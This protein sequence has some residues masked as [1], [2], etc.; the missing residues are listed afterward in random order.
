MKAGARA[1]SFVTVTAAAGWWLGTCAP[2]PGSA[3]LLGIAA[4]DGLEHEQ[5]RIR[6]LRVVDRAH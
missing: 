4:G 1:P 3:S 6:N 2:G 5:T